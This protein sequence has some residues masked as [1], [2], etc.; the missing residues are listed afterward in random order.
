MEQETQ[1]TTGSVNLLILDLDGTVRAPLSG[2]KFIQRPH[3]QKMIEGAE[4]AIAYFAANGWK[5]VGVTNQAGVASG[6]KS[7]Q[8]CIKE[9]QYTLD[10]VPEM[11]E[12]YFCPDFEGGK[13]FCVT[14]NEVNNYSNHQESGK[15]RK[16]NAGMLKLA[17][18]IHKPDKVLMIGDRP[19]DR[20][21]ASAA[22]A[23]FQHAENW[24][25]TYGDTDF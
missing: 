7:L 21:A 18:E 14:S 15:F 12:I 6:K 8:S 19:E 3:D 10:L 13:C 11:E 9:Q 5:I 4:G 1:E 2:N 16:P 23:K 22:G 20:Q 24:R 25:Q 17:I